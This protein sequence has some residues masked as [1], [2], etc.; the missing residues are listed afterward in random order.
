MVTDFSRAA[1][2]TMGQ[3]LPQH[4]F[5]LNIVGKAVAEGMQESVMYIL[6]E[7]PLPTESNLS[8]SR[9]DKYHGPRKAL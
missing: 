1:L 3:R 2:N 9:G 5:F 4:P 8:F 7:P 6:T